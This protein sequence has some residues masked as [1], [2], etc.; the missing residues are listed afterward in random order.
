MKKCRKILQM[1]AP[2]N[3]LVL[4]VTSK[5]SSSP[6]ISLSTRPT[7][8]HVI[9]ASI[10]SQFHSMI[11]FRLLA[12][13]IFTV[14]TNI[15][16]KSDHHNKKRLYHNHFP[17]LLLLLLPCSLRSCFL[18]PWS[19]CSDLELEFS[20]WLSLKRQ[21]ALAEICRMSPLLTDFIL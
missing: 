2:N 18:A 14:A 17:A 6:F 16:H 21:T 10:L 8:S 19:L 20:C 3:T 9:K 5:T 11:I 12:D 15:Y 4:A 7:F 13:S 1:I